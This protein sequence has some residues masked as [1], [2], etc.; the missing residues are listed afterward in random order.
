MFFDRDLYLEKIEQTES[1]KAMTDRYPNSTITT[2]K[3]A[4][5]VHVEMF[6]HNDDGNELAVRISYDQRNTDIREHAN[7]NLLDSGERKNLGTTPPEVIDDPSIPK[8]VFLTGSA[9][10]EF[11][12]SFIKYTNCLDA[13]TPQVE[14][15]LEADHYVAI[16]DGT[17]FP[18]CQESLSCFEP[19]SLKI[20][21]GDVVS[22]RNFGSVP[23]TV[24]SGFWR[25]GPD[26]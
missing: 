6:A 11:S 12:A 16:P 8:R 14:G 2:R 1:Y 20:K 21:V 9:H 4:G 15:E 5:S 22:F 24:T 18:G 13:K 7:C 23:H 26:G 17:E 10:N 25:A 19:Y 3:L